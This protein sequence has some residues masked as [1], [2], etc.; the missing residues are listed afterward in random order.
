MCFNPNQE[1]C[2]INKVY[3]HGNT[4]FLIIEKSNVK[5]INYLLSGVF[6]YK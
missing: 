6:R 5:N 4:A 3:S 2:M 1:I